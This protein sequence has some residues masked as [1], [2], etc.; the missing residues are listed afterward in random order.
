MIEK[1]N[2]GKMLLSLLISVQPCLQLFCY[3]VDTEELLTNA[4]HQILNT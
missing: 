2:L 1:N 3:I 4:F